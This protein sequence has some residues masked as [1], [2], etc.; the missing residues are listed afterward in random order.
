MI[1]GYDELL[2]FS[3]YVCDEKE[4]CTIDKKY[5]LLTI[6]ESYELLHVTIDK[7]YELLTQRTVDKNYGLIV[8]LNFVGS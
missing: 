3:F 7:N 6:D 4:L 8:R 1:K 5:E 2:I